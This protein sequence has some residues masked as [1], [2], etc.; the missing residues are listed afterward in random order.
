MQIHTHRY[1]QTHTYTHTCNYTTY[2]YTHTLKHFPGLAKFVP[3]A[4][5]KMNKII[6]AKIDT[7]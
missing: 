2:T 1:T 6:F 5:V 3:S 4:S 7:F